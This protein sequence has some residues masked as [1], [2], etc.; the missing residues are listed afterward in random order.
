MRTDISRIPASRRRAGRERGSI[1]ILAALSAAVL[2]AFT[3]LALDASYMY[4]HKRR[5]QTAADAGAYAGALEKLRGTTDIVVAARKDSSLNGFT[6]G[7]NDVAVEVNSPPA[8]GPRAGDDNFVE[9]VVSQAQPTWFMRM[10]NF[11]SVMVRARA[12]AGLGNTNNGCVFALNQDASI[13]TNGIFVNGT[14]DS[15]MACGVYSNSNFRASGGGCVVAPNVSYLADYTNHNSSG[16]CGPDGLAPGVP[17]V[18]PL[19]GRFSIPSYG[20]CTENNFKVTGGK[21][22]TINP[23]TYCG[24]ISITGTVENVVF[25]PGDYILVGGGMKINGSVNVS[26]A[27]VTFYN[28]FPGSRDNQYDGISIVTSGVVN[29]SAPT[30]GANKGLLFYQDPRVAWTANN[31]SQI[32]G[33]NAVYNGI[34]YFPS[35][36][37]Q[38]SGNSSANSTGTDGYTMIIGYNIKVNG[39]ARINSDY[40]AIGGNPLRNALFAE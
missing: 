9:V 35:T 34:L 12:V 16:E 6:N 27:A 29:M 40:S 13:S 14:T 15:R 19:R 26:G 39:S 18:D 25:N 33:T 1:V 36:D 23:G 5:M 24:G 32:A 37:L 22:V 8:S 31:G 2:M 20:G 38:Y 28:T 7:S 11:N 17:V 30:A 10:L 4:F 21:M 3:G